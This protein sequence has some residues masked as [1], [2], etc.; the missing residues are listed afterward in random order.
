[1]VSVTAWSQERRVSL[2]TSIPFF[3]KA[4]GGRDGAEDEE[5]VKEVLW[6]GS[7]SD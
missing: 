1:M 3:T 5:R 2:S 6:L 7:L 4:P